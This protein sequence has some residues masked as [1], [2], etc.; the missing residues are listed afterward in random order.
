MTQ[1]SGKSYLTI[2]LA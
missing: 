1:M 2:S